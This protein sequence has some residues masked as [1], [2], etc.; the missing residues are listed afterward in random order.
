MHTGD[1]KEIEGVD[2][3]ITFLWIKYNFHETFKW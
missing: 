3:M 2:E 1:N